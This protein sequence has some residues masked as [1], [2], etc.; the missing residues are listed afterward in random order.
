MQQA[1]PIFIVGVGRSGTSLLQSI[2][3]TH[4]EIGVVPETSFLRRYALD[5]KINWETINCDEMLSRHPQLLHALSGIKQ[6]RNELIEVY[7]KS[8]LSSPQ[9]YVLD[10]DPRLIEYVDLLNQMNSE[11]KIIEIRRDPRDVLCSKKKANWSKGRSIISYLL[12]SYI[13]LSDGRKHT[14]DNNFY[15]LQYEELLQ[16]PIRQIKGICEFLDIQFE[17][18]MLEFQQTAE[19]LIQS[20]ELS[21]KKET[22][23]PILKENIGKW[24]GELSDV[25]SYSSTEVAISAVP[26]I[27]FN[28]SSDF[29]LFTKI[30]GKLLL[31]VIKFMSVPYLFM[32][33]INRKLV[34]EDL[35]KA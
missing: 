22:L 34:K 32:R 28:D 2:V 15:S 27:Q 25:E 26:E 30:K 31:L 23:E 8:I 33:K 19:K 12:A 29:G 10:K 5:A 35:A 17:I 14:N 3:G 1:K 11:C 18:G 20:D 4:S 24:K 21:W 16:D 9:Q 13:Q 7:K 6:Q